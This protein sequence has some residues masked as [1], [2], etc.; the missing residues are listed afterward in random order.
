M[1][2]STEGGTFA[3]YSASGNLEATLGQARR[4]PVWGI[5]VS[6][7]YQD[8]IVLGRDTKAGTHYLSFFSATGQDVA[9]IGEAIDN[10]AGIAL[11]FD[12]SGNLIA[13]MAVRSDGKG[14]VDVLG[15]NKV[16]I[17]QLTESESGGGKLWIGNAGGVG[18]VEAGDAGGYGI[19][20]AGPEGFKF[21][22][23]PGLALPGNVIVGKR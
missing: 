17:A 3:A 6:E 8:R 4:R 18:M 21:I 23:T 12:K 22:P 20:H 15:V 14:V 1:S 7:K 11:V 19:V 5:S 2:A 10:R 9:G 13:R 16:P